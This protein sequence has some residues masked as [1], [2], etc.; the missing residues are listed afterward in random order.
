[1][2]WCYEQALKRDPMLKVSRLDVDWVATAKLINIRQ[3]RV[4]GR[5]NRIVP[6][7][8]KNLLQSMPVLV[9][10]LFAGTRTP[11]GI[12]AAR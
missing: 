8:V 6:G 2:K 12:R 10:E 1:M 3:S 4:E 11:D 9:H 7:D 5:A